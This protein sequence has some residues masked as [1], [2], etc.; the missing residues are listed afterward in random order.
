MLDRYHAKQ[1]TSA[2]VV[3]ALVRLAKKLRAQRDRNE[4]LG[5]TTQELAFYDVLVAKQDEWVDDPRLKDIAGEIVRSLTRPDDP[6]LGADWTERSNL[7]AKVRVRIKQIL[8][9]N[10]KFLNLNGG[11]FDAVVDRV[12]AQAKTLYER[13]PEVD[14]LP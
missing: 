12:F 14:P 13:W 11:G 7:E 9:R 1:L 5:L 3:T 4:Q 10:R 2:D 6:A 8:R